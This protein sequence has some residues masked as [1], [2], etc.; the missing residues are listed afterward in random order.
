MRHTYMWAFALALSLCGGISTVGQ[1][2]PIPKRVDQ[3]IVLS[4]P[5]M[6]SDDWYAANGSD[7]T[8]KVLT[9]GEQVVARSAPSTGRSRAKL[10]FRV[11]D[12]AIRGGGLSSIKVEDGWLLG[13][14]QGEWGGDIWWYS[15][16]GKRHYKISDE[17]VIGFFKTSSGLFACEGLAHLGLDYGHVLSLAQDGKGRWKSEPFVNLEHAPE[18]ARVTSE[19]DLLIAT[20]TTLV[21]V[22]ANKSVDV[23]VKDAFWGALYPESILETPNGDIYL[24]MRHG[25]ARIR[26]LQTNNSKT[27]K[28]DWL[29]PNQAFV[30]AKSKYWR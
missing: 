6:G 11:T 15:M 17:Q 7:Y 9:E 12:P 8:W 24:G 20:T 14:N 21:R 19:G 1:T 18:V 13:R 4:P 22:K 27:Y 3:W 25:I 28:V 29:L 30:H 2:P 5:K 16:D 26:P 10:P 23:L